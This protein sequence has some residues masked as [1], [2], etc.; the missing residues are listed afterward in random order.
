M[1]FAGWEESEERTRW[2]LL[3]VLLFS[4]EAEAA[5]GGQVGHILAMDRA[6]VKGRFRE[7]S[8]F[9]G[10]R[11]AEDGIAARVSGTARREE[12]SIS[13]FRSIAAAR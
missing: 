2:S 12:G 5:E 1:R 7:R 4:D 10:R 11:T 3:S 13:R 9:T 8:R 6:P